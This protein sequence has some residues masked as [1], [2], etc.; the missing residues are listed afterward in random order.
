MAYNLTTNT[1]N[2]Y[3]HDSCLRNLDDSRRPIESDDRSHEGGAEINA[4]GN[5]VE[6][7]ASESATVASH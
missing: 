7:C 1:L 3:N 5:R 6:R 4:P 2:K